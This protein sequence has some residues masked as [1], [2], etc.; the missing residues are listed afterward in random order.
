M[1]G[2]L[3]IKFLVDSATLKKG[4][5]NSKKQL[6]GF[7]KATKKITGGIGKALGGFGIALGASALISG[8]K[9]ATKAAAED[10]KQQKLL[11]GQLQRTT[12]ATKAQVKGAE[13][14]I[15]TLSKQTGVLD[16][17]LRPALANAVRGSG[18]LAKGQELLRI[19]LDGSVASGKPLD[20]VLNALIKANNGNKTSLYRLAPE[21]KKT[22]GNIDDYAK[23]VKG[24]A[25]AGADPFAKFNVAV[26][27]L[28]E[29]FG[30][31]LLPY[32]EKFV[33]YLTKTAIPAVEDFI[34][35]ASDPSTDVGKTF[36]EIGDA[37]KAVFNQVKDFFALFGNGDAAKGFANVATSLVKALP[38]LLALKGILT[39]AAA[40]KS[41]TALVAAIAALRGADGAGVVG[42]KG[43]KGTT[44]LLGVNPAT[45][46]AAGVL[47]LGGDTQKDKP[48][49]PVIPK[50]SNSV[51]FGQLP[52]VGKGSGLSLNDLNKIRASSYTININGAKMTPNEI[53]AAIKKYERETGNK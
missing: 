10:L 49:T 15:D 32:V 50:V 46:V 36:R 2:E 40:G 52:V 53:V 11:A 45:L 28:Q 26:E 24:A 1:A 19:A 18:S 12:G 5:N 7:E 31:K 4:L 8:L 16:D 27:N 48:L 23:S 6:S 42:G 35:Q 33:G 25:E 39:L 51:T 20:T 14:F 47:T 44:P 30:A 3:S 21:L 17:D 9:E 41:L 22:S 29:S 13:S 38:A 37:V 34:D 43:G